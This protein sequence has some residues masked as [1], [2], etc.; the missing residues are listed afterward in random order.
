MLTSEMIKAKAREYGADICGIAPI[1][2]FADAPLQRDPKGILPNATCVLGF[3]FR[4]PKGLYYCMDKKTQYNN[5]TN[6]GVKYIDEELSEIFLLKMARVI[7]NEGFDACVQ[8][9]VSNLKIKGDKTQNPE[10]LDTYELVPFDDTCVIPETQTAWFNLERELIRKE[11]RQEDF[12][13]EETV[14]LGML[15]EFSLLKNEATSE[16]VGS[17]KLRLDRSGL[18][19]E[20]TREGEEVKLH[21]TLERI[22]RLLFGAG[23]NFEIY[24][25]SEIYF[26]V[27]EEK[28]SAV[29]WYTASMILHDMANP[30]DQ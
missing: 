14:Q 29:D 9:N 23:V 27:P 19:Y 8:R 4:V 5:Y 24:D 6:L 26:F 22:Y 2:R 1:E 13:L 20:G 3:G 16:I 28:R 12:V 11:V 7:E 10:L 15:P 25:G 30:A 21:F 17:G 18:T